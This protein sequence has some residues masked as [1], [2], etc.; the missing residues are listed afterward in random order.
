MKVMSK[1]ILV[2]LTAILLIAGLFGI[3]AFAA[4]N[5][6]VD[7][8]VCYEHGDVNSD[9]SITGDD[10]VYLLFASFGDL[11][12]DEYKL[13]QDGDLDGD[14]DVTGEDAVYLLF[15]SFGDMF[16]DEYPLNGTVHSYYDPI[17]T[18]NTDAAEPTAQVSLKCACGENHTITEGIAITAGTV[19]NP[20]C[21]ATG[22]KVYTGSVTFENNTY[23]NTVT[24]TLPALGE[25]GHSIVG[26]PTCESGV[27]C[28]NCD[29]TVEALGH[30]YVDNGEKVDGCKHT[31]LYKCACGSETEG[32]VYYTHS[33]TAEL[34]EEAT[35]TR[36]GKKLLTCTCGDT[37]EETVPVNPEFHVWGEAVTE[38]GVTTQTCACGETK[39]I[40]VMSD[41]GVAAD[42]LKD[43]EVQLDGGTSVALDEDTAQQLD[44]EKSVVITVEQVDKDQT[45][46]SADEKEQVGDNA[47]YDF[48]MKY[49]DGTPIT[50]FAG[51]ITV[52]LPYTL[53]EG[54]DVNAID[55]WF[56]ADDGSVECVK[57]VYSNNYVT[58]K[59]SHFSYY[60]VTRLTPEQRCAVYGHVTVERTKEATCT[61]DG[62]HKV[63]CQRCGLEEKN[64]VKAMLGHDYQKDAQ[65]SKDATCDAPGILA[66]QCANCGHKRLQEIKQLSH[67]WS[68]ETVAPTC[69]AKG[70]DKRTC[71]LCGVEK[72]DNEKEALGHNFTQDS[73]AWIW[74]DDYSKA[75]VTVTCAN[76]KTHTK[77]LSAVITTKGGNACVGGQVT[78][79]AT[80]SFNKVTY[81]VTT[82]AEQA[83]VGHTPN[84]EWTT[85]DEKH[86]HT[87]SVCGE[88]VGEAVHDW[89]RKV[90]TAA[91]CTKDGS[92]TDTCTV[93][94]KEKAV[95]LTATG[96]HSFKNGTCT[97]C[98]YTEGSCDH[99]TLTVVEIDMSEY[100]AC[101]GTIT[102]RTCNCGQVTNFYDTNLTCELD[103][104]EEDINEEQG[105]AKISAGCTKCDFQVELLQKIVTDKE[106]CAAYY[107]AEYTIS[108]G[109]TLVVET[110]D[111]STPTKHPL[112]VKHDPINLADY[113]LCELELVNTTCYCGYRSDWD[114][115]GGCDMVF[116]EDGETFSCS[117]CGATGTNT[118]K[119]FKNGCE[120][121][122]EAVVT[123][124]KNGNQVFTATMRYIQDDHDYQVGHYE[125]AGETCEDGVS[126]VTVCK[127]C[128]I[129]EKGYHTDCV[130]FIDK[131]TI[132]TSATGSCA[133]GIVVRTC[134]CG[135]LE[136]WT[137]TFDDEMTDHN[138]QY[139]YDDETG[140]YKEYCVKCGFSL[141]SVS[142]KIDA[143]QKDDKCRVSYD[144][145]YTYFN[146]EEGHTFT[147]ETNSFV[148]RHNAEYEFEMMGESCVDGVTVYRSCADCGLVD[149][150]TENNHMMFPVQVVDLSQ[151]GFCSGLVYLR[152]CPCG[153]YSYFNIEDEACYWQDVGYEEGAYEMR[154][155]ECGISRVTR[156]NEM[157]TD[158]PCTQLTQYEVTFLKDGQELGTVE[159]TEKWTNHS[160]L[161][162][163]T[164]FEGAQSC[165]DGYYLKGVCQNC[166]ETSEYEEW[167]CR[168][169]AVSREVVSTDDMCGVMEIV[170]YACACGGKNYEGMR[171]QDETQRCDFY[172]GEQEYNDEYNDWQYFCV[173]GASRI[174]YNETKTIEGETCLR[175]HK[176]EHF[177]FAPNGEL[178]A[179]TSSI[180]VAEFHDWL[181]DFTLLGETCDDGWTCSVYC[182][183]CGK[184][185]S[186]Q[187]T[188]YGHEVG[189]VERE[190]VYDSEDV[191]GPVY[192]YRQVCACGQEESYVVTDSCEGSYTNGLFTCRTCGLQHK[193]SYHHERIPGTCRVTIT[194]TYTIIVS[195]ET[196]ATVTREY[197]EAEHEYV[198]QMILLGE[199]CEDG[200]RLVNTCAFCD[201]NYMH[202]E[203]YYGHERYRLEYYEAPEGS[204]G[205]TIEAFGCA[206]GKEREMRDWLYCNMEGQYYNVNEETGEERWTGQC[207]ICGLQAEKVSIVTTGAN[208]CLLVANCTWTYTMGDQTFTVTGASIEENH[209]WNVEGAELRYEGSQS[210]EDGVEIYVRCSKC[211][212]TSTWYT[213]GHEQFV[214]ESESID[215]AAYGSVCG[216]KLQLKTCACGKLRNYVLSEDTKCDVGYNSTDAWIEGALNDEYSTTEGW[217]VVYSNFYE[218]YCAVTDPACGLRMRMACYWLNENCTAVEYETW[219]LGYDPETGDCDKELTVATGRTRTYHAYVE[220]DE[221]VGEEEGMRTSEQKELCPDCGSYCLDKYY[222]R[223][224]NTGLAKEVREI[225]NTLN[226]GEGK[227]FTNTWEY[228]PVTDI[229]DNSVNIPKLTRGEYVYADGN[230]YW[231]LNEYSYDFTDG[232]KRTRTYSDSNG[233]SYTEVD[234]EYHDTIRIRERVKQPTCSQ[235]GCDADRWICRICGTITEEDIITVYPNDHS[236]SYDAEKQTH[237]CSVCGLENQNGTSGSI[238]MEDL[239][240]EDSY[241]VGY[242]CVNDISFSPYVSLILYDAA[243]D[244][245]DELVLDSISVSYQTIDGDGIC[246]LSFSKAATAEA[247]AAALEAAGYTGS[248]AVRISC[249]PVG[250][251]HELD[252]AVTFDTL[253]VE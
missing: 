159:Y 249:V 25:D 187:E 170:T 28:E 246:G 139:D 49:S 44:A 211:G 56:I 104:G 39:T 252:Y 228:I 195:G 45:G 182:A 20:T 221:V 62:Y 21:V 66:T 219:Q 118:Y 10:A 55:V 133:T 245:N 150:W 91:T 217:N 143:S 14:G 75:T 164:L 80:A 89:E 138:W 13:T 240:N 175:E 215:L 19:V 235:P 229:Y 78:Y 15:A 134:A 186:N 203:I 184:A 92:A 53:Q 241:V 239:S 141:E 22:S 119:T 73:A 105:Y 145:S 33:Y 155:T 46:M 27:K 156:W 207:T 12:G 214:D 169:Y 226:N 142:S 34:Q 224:D 148:T 41:E 193:N 16:G 114:G 149:D 244:Q 117:V 126:V 251:A 212:E 9:G 70:Y 136:D 166:G 128:G 97:V 7:E 107:T 171:W 100:G 120:R 168:E 43:S 147:W 194:M 163:L 109:N 243:E 82:T 86:Y 112:M 40:V 151:Y 144:V 230:T 124:F 199:T 30:N 94:G 64:E 85:N 61:E 209:D 238:W 130:T 74:S 208:D 232:C 63:F 236:W 179:Q 54:D 79:T 153:E 87:C 132:D 157:E 165:N 121:I 137:Y 248:Y 253:T 172:S 26:E 234:E 178:I 116:E 123:F 160:E 24:V 218:R 60:T 223:A 167:G 125:M 185:E 95:V 47:I 5:D 59:T 23:E 93:C 162:E 197:T 202:D 67:K 129:E 108:V 191:C 131:E 127:E 1:R 192:V 188:Q 17:W 48:S 99:K 227:Q 11:F 190:L 216:A 233:N 84:S 102:V 181:Y 152:S 6:P 36:P 32:D 8:P 58:F 122:E 68:L 115:E 231:Y 2:L 96:K 135:S 72:I 220:Q 51:E 189:D 154:C 222:F 88:P 183:D 177:Y 110:Y 204:C 65:L 101:E 31:K 35:C 81:T 210:C 146:A 18:W 180:D 206:C 111:E 225:V 237:V 205:G 103:E 4:N 198:H 242:Y 201:Y 200:Y 174:N 57:G 37:Q 83:G 161:Y 173:C 176:F 213:E 71:D 77:E 98:G 29:Y 196:V 76:D 69:S 140:E 250:G 52:A 106:N 3:T 247:A 113:G 42:A 38:G 90:I 50:S 158:E